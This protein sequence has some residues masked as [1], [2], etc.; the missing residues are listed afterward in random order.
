MWTGHHLGLEEESRI[1]FGRSWLGVVEV[2]A[3]GYGGVLPP[4]F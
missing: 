2:V 3:L 1:E 4:P